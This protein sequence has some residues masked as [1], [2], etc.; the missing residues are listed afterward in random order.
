MEKIYLVTGATGFVGNNV[1]RLLAARGEKV[2]TFVYT[3]GKEKTALAG[4][5]AEIV[6]GDIRNKSDLERLFVDETCEYVFIHTAAEVDIG[7]T[8]FS[9]KMY[10]INVSGT[11]NVL[12]VCREHGVSRLVYVSS[13]HAITEPKKKAMTYEIENFEPKSVH[14]AYAKTKS[15]ASALIMQAV[16]DGLNAVMVHPSGI[17][18]PGDYSNTHTTQLVSDFAARRIPAGVTGGYDFVDVRDVAKAVV[19]A[20]DTGAAGSRWL[21][22]GGFIS[23]KNL[24]NVMRKVLTETPSKKEKKLKI[25]P[26]WLAQTGLP[27]MWLF[28]KFRNKR[29]LYTR[30]SLYTL[31]SNGNF[32][33][34]KARA[35]LGH[36]PIPIETSIRDTV[37]FLKSTNQLENKWQ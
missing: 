11:K 10:D 35:E 4:V 2:R 17:V 20:C 28:A 14:G 30:Y 23:V 33:S 12:E 7:V 31:R 6:Y 25:Y 13:V 34:D 22:T 26:M 5:P 3:E 21:V 8:G 15:T 32:C 19:T 37:E 29:P 16:N 18:G 1:V 27:F 9:Q 24:L 36:N